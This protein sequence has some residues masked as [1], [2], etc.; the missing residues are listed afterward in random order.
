LDTARLV[1]RFQAGERDVFAELYLRYFDRVY[2]YMRVL[3]RAPDAA[4]EATQEVF[5]KA[6]AGLP[7]YERRESPFSAWLFTVVRNHALTEIERQR[8][9][10]PVDPADLTERES[11][12]PDDDAGLSALNWIS[13]REL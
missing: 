13:D 8:R 3:L 9:S 5:A 2:G 4:E 6:L 11:E 7:R 10:E 12:T 1:I